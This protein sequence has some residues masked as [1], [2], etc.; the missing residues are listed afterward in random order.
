MWDLLALFHLPQMHFPLILC[1]WNELLILVKSARFTIPWLEICK[2]I[3]QNPAK[4]QQKIGHLKGWQGNLLSWSLSFVLCE[5]P[6]ST[7]RGLSVLHVQYCHSLHQKWFNSEML[8]QWLY[9]KIWEV[10]WAP[11]LC[12]EGIILEVYKPVV[13]P[14]HFILAFSQGIH[15]GLLG[16][17]CLCFICTTTLQDWLG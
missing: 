3:V 16:S 12:S 14:S 7:S 8:L 4:L 17:S 15:G 6:R 2:E 13:S 5:F 9:I 1:V 10:V 11:P